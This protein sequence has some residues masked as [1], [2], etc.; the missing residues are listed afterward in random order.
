MISPPRRDEEA[1]AKVSPQSA[2]QL[3]RQGFPQI[4]PLPTPP[5]NSP[6]SPPTSPIPPPPP[7]RFSME[8]TVKLPLFKGLGNEDLD[9]FWF[10]VRAVWEARDVTN[11]LI[12]KVTLVSALEDCVLTWYIKYSNDNLNAGV[13]DI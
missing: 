4:P 1:I 12:N 5:L 3:I 13:A 2:I 9:Q 7:L 8:K 6:P 10:V 11:D